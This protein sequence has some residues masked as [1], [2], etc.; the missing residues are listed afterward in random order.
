MSSSEANG[1]LTNG[2]KRILED[3]TVL[4][5]RVHRAASTD[6]SSAM[7]TL[8]LRREGCFMRAVCEPGIA[9]PASLERARTVTAES[10]VRVTTAARPGGQSPAQ[11]PNEAGSTMIWVAELLALST[12]KRGNYE[13][14]GWHGAPGEAPLST[15]ALVQIEQRL[16]DRILDA[17]VA[18]TAAIFKLSS[19]IH[20]ICVAHLA[21]LSFCNIQT[22]TFIGY[23]YPGEEDDHFAVPY[24]GRTA[25][26]TPTSE[27]HLGMALAADL[28]RVYDIHSVFRREGEVDRRH[29]TEV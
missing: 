4:D 25:W 3:I 20:E 21:A 26:L 11:D 15:S 7:I 8:V 29:L 1:K 14:P 18:A 24:F 27:V 10:L 22:P 28:E 16:D 2:A 23:E 13:R 12:A 5:A 6:A 19:G 9:D 17:R